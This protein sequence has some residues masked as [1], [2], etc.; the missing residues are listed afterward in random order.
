MTKADNSLFYLSG[1]QVFSTSNIYFWMFQNAVACPFL[2]Q[3]QSLMANISIV[4]MFKPLHNHNS[5]SLTLFYSML[6]TII[7]LSL[8]FHLILSVLSLPQYIYFALMHSLSIISILFPSLM[9]SLLPSLNPSIHTS[10]P[11]SISR[12]GTS[13]GTGHL[14]SSENTCSGELWGLSMSL[15]Y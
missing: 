1:R 8:T 4:Q 11:P 9:C 5:H 15:N 14:Q 13:G 12:W 7:D 10:L 3:W 2:S 6:S